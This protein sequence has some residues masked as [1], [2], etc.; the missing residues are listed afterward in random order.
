[1]SSRRR[2]RQRAKHAVLRAVRSGRLHRP[3]D[4]SRCGDIPRRPVHGHHPDYSKPL[5]VEW[6][7][8]RCH[9]DEH[10]KLNQIA[11]NRL[12]GVIGKYA[13]NGEAAA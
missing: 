9:A 7:C 12:L 10:V 8:Q 1:M 5:Q 6:L 4:C 3:V 11:R 2:I 13:G